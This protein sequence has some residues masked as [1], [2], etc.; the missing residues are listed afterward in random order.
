MTPHSNYTMLDN[1]WKR[2]NGNFVRIPNSVLQDSNLSL[3]AKGGIWSL[4]IRPRIPILIG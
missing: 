2:P 1:Y 3:S 4:H